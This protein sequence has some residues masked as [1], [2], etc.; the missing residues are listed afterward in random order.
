MRAN[1]QAQEEERRR[2]QAEAVKRQK[3]QA[4]S[5][6]RRK[7]GEASGLG[8]APQGVPK[9]VRALEKGK[10]SERASCDHCM[11]QRVVCEV[12]YFFFV[13]IPMFSPN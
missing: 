11:A 4:E 6:A 10:G 1:A 9:T 5:E 2:A 8:S 3:A 12:S 13:I 7:A